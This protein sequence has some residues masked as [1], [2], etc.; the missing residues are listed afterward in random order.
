MPTCLTVLC[1]K[2]VLNF[3]RYNK[4][5]RKMYNIK[6]VWRPCFSKHYM[7]GWEKEDGHKIYRRALRTLILLQCMP[8]RNR[9]Q[10]KCGGTR[11]HTGEE[12]KGK[13]AN[14]VGSHYPSNY[15]GIWCIQHYYRWWAQLGWTDAPADLNVLVR[16]AERRN[17]VSARVPSH[18]KR[19]LP[20]YTPNKHMEYVSRPRN[21]IRSGVHRYLLCYYICIY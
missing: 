4:T 3:C 15:L 18:F 17:L 7:R 20:C 9:L 14:G 12:M 16:F 19:S 6:I 21:L 11:W 8:R 1:N 2:L 10:L 5:A 13:M